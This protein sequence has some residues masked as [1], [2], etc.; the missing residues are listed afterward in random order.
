MKTA[1]A[2]NIINIMAFTINLAA[3]QFF[4]DFAVD[5]EHNVI[6]KKIVPITGMTDKIYRH[7]HSFILVP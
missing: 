6:I 7:I 1:I 3:A 4:T 5:F 2:A